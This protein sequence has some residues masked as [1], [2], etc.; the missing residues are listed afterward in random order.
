MNFMEKEKQ[1]RLGA[2]DFAVK[3]ESARR[4]A[5]FHLYYGVAAQLQ[6]FEGWEQGEMDDKP[7]VVYDLSGLPLFYDFPI[8][9]GRSY[10]GFIRI[11]A[12]KALGDSVVSTYVMWPRW[13]VD[14]A[15][16]KLEKWAK[17]KYP[18]DTIKSVKLVC[19]SYP[20]LALSAELASPKGDIELLLIDIG[21]FT[22]IVPR[23]EPI[24]KE[25][26]QVPYSL[27]NK[28]PEERVKAGPKIWDKI[29]LETEK[30]FKKESKLEPARMYNLAPRERL[31]VIAKVFIDI[32]PKPDIPPE[33]IQ[34]HEQKMINYCCHHDGYHRC[35]CLHP[36][37]KPFNSAI[38][39]TQMVLCYWRYCY[40]QNE[41]AHFI[42]DDNLDPDY[43]SYGVLVFLLDFTHNCFDVGYSDA[44]NLGS[45]K[46]ELRNRRPFLLGGLGGHTRVCAGGHWWNIVEPLKTNWLYIFDPS[47]PG[48]EYWERFDHVY[49]AWMIT[50]GREAIPTGY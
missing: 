26:G 29:N 34:W 31:K 8:R 37:E 10:L 36:E 32:M 14:A 5:Q 7:R 13:D 12:N 16:K 47:G 41:I 44:V 19:Y 27:L 42:I 25:L 9:R 1:V 20:K 18:K 17:E 23:P 46:I 38:A 2:E 21:D 33:P 30:L 35:F 50:L 15:Q 45:C 3:A 39:S 49:H 40:S 43:L 48:A 6:G 11:A 22:E 28:I 24:K 4:H